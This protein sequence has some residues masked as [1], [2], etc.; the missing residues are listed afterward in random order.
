[1]PFYR[2]LGAEESLFT[3]LDSEEATVTLK[4]QY[5]MNKSITKLA[6]ALTYSGALECG[7]EEVSKATMKVQLQT[8]CKWLSRALSTQIDQSVTLINTGNVHSRC[9]AFAKGSAEAYVDETKE[10]PDSRLYVNYCEAAVIFTLV[11]ELLDSGMQGSS[12]GVIAPYVLQV[13]FLKKILSTLNGDLEMNTVDQYQGRDK[14]VIIYSGTRTGNPPRSK[15]NR[16][17]F[18]ILE[19][20]RRLTVAITR[21]K[22]KLLLI[23]DEGALRCYE[24]FKRLFESL[25]SLNKINLA[26]GQMDFDWDGIGKCVNL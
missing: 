17:K 22:H 16:S 14:E 10:K 25:P 3:S 5:R 4:Q 2:L 18:E 19:D 13:N 7:N 9:K 6:N 8:K 15:S 21:A 20:K 23:G 12:I 24:P 11:K 26:Q 1:M